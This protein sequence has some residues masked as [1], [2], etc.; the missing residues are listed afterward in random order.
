MALTYKHMVPWLMKTVLCTKCICMYAP[1]YKGTS[2]HVFESPNWI[3]HIIASY[4]CSIHTIK[5][6]CLPTGLT[7]RVCIVSLH[8]RYVATP[9]VLAQ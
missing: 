1:I 6:T 8:V 7:F 4:N 5:L 3:L 2:C 9:D